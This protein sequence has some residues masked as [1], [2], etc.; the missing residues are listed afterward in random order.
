MIVLYEIVKKERFEDKHFGR[1]FNKRADSKD[2]DKA[3]DSYHGIVF[4]RNI[5]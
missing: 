1:K 5:V 4:S 3:G 2:P